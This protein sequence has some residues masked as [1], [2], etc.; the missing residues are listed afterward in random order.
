VLSDFIIKTI[1]I[2]L[3][4]QLGLHFWP[5]FS[6]VAGIK[7]DY[8]SP[9]LYFLDLLLL[10]LVILNYQQLFRFIRNNQKYFILL[11]LYVSLNI[12]FAVSPPNSFFWWLRSLL[13]LSVFFV[14]RL[15]H[16]NWSQIRTPLFYGTL[17]V[18]VIEV[19]QLLQQSSIGGPLYFLGERAFSA[20]TPGL[21]RLNLFGS[22]LIRPMSVFSHPNSLAGYLLVVFYLFSR[23]KSPS[24]YKLVPFIGILLTFSKTAIISLSLIIFRFRPEIIIL[25]SF[26]LTYLQPF[27]QNQISNLQSLATRQFY[28][29]YL[30][31]IA[32]DHSLFGVGLGN[33][34]P[35]LGRVLPGSF[36]TPSIL[37]PI[38]NLFYLCLAEI[39]FIGT[40]IL[41]YIMRQVKKV[42]LNREVLGLLALILI[43]GTFDHYTLTLPQNKLIL[44][45]ALSIMF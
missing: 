42:T 3:P 17:M 12:I 35:A 15:R 41:I 29:N 21:G 43:T 27:L 28:F 22:E 26:L 38:H 7:I 1:V 31:K 9:T 8:L 25:F 24:C 33:Y 11:L 45:L 18:V 2:L 6:R 37:Q 10:M 34:I 20:S 23:Q 32:L 19:L 44:L 13:Y 40:A 5:S 14:L 39:G 4:T 30:P 16:L 36:L